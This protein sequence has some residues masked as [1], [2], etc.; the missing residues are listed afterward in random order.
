MKNKE[1]NIYLSVIY[2]QIRLVFSS[3]ITINDA[4]INE[5]L[6]WDVNDFNHL[7]LQDRKTFKNLY[8]NKNSRFIKHFNS[9]EKVF[10][11]K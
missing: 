5:K 10:F 1:L 2:S 7:N 4:L 8:Q 11:S 6:L 3:F 9:V